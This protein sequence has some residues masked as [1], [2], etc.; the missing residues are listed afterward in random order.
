[1]QTIEIKTPS[2][3]SVI[4]AGEG[5]FE[6]YAKEISGNKFVITDSNVYKLYS[7]LIESAFGSAPTYVIPAGEGSKDKN[8]LFKIL[9]KMI[10]AGAT[11]K[12]T[13]IALG[14]GVVGD[15]A[16]LAASLY[17]RGVQIVQIPT[18]LLSQ[19]DSSV[20][21]KT[22]VDFKGVKNVIGTFYQPST[23]IV[24]PMFLK[25]LPKR[26]LKCGLGE[27][28][29]YGALN[30]AIYQKLTENMDNLFDLRF[31]DGIT[32]DCIRH[33]AKVVTEDERDVSGARKAL[34]LGH[35]TGHAF[36]LYYKRKSHGE[37]VLIGM[38]YELYIAEKAGVCSVAY[39][40]GLRRLIKKVIGKVPAYGDAAQASLMAKYDK[41][42]AE[43]SAVSMI[44]PKD[45]GSCTEYVL[46]LKE[47]AQQ[48]GECAQLLRGNL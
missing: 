37:F 26:E 36:E 2:V 32:A 24:D 8:T 7:S 3:N 29:K 42:N 11:R 38:Y 22:A 28:V 41:K 14:G 27:I 18:T 16:G 45:I 25:T 1:M 17:M 4:Y 33:K 39:A 23:V 31:L 15:V 43:Q 9:D 48:I 47:Y 40:D 21:G 12:T 20:G 34:N 6:R 10:S 44:V 19:V 5:A 35:T 13:V 46:P 30:G